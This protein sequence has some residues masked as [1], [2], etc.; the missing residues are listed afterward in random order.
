M[1]SSKYETLNKM[2]KIFSKMNSA[3]NTNA[4]KNAKCE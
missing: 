1:V 2:E 3:I 4:R